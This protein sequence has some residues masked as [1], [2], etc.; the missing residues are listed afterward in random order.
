[1]EAK[2]PGMSDYADFDPNGDN[3]ISREEIEFEATSDVRSLARRVALQVLYEVDSSRHVISDVMRYHLIVDDVS[4][5][6]TDIDHEMAL[7]INGIV[8]QLPQ[9]SPIAIRLHQY[10][11]AYDPATGKI[12]DQQSNI[13]IRISAIV[14]Y[15]EAEPDVTRL[16]HGVVKHQ[17]LLDSVIQ[18]Y[19]PEFPIDQVAIIDRNVL[20]LSLYELGFETQTPTSVAIDEAVTLARLF[21]SE[22]SPRFVNGVLGT[23][24]VNIDAVRSVLHP[25]ENTNGSSST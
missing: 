18:S 20:R 17:E 23:V 19:A 10:I 11:Q 3:I 21:G 5:K 1:M 25:Q 13:A 22:G 16:T 14:K 4:G 9:D 24:A 6:I 8:R 15:L 2:N 7:M 12:R